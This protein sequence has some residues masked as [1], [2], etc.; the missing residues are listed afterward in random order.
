MDGSQSQK[1][2]DNS[3]QMQARRDATVVNNYFGLSYADVKLAIAEERERIVQHVWDLAQKMLREAGAQPRP[4]PLKII[5]A[6]LQCAS[7]EEDGDLQERWA[8]LLANASATGPAKVHE[9]FSEVLRQLS[10]RESRFLDHLYD[11]A[12]KGWESSGGKDPYVPAIGFM[13]PVFT[14]EALFQQYVEATEMGGYV[15]WLVAIS[16]ALHTVDQMHAAFSV[17]IDN[18]LRL[19]LIDVEPLPEEPT[20]EESKNVAFAPDSGRPNSKWFL[21]SFGFEFISVCRPP[22]KAPGS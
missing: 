4:V 9:S 12:V 17:S 13:F 3:T 19:R 22:N 6:L 14:N 8:A 18:L 5:V 16:S 15:G 2:G 10:P 20:E 1:A 11:L 7:L 21:T